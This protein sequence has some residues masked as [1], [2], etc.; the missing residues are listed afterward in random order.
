MLATADLAFMRG[1]QADALPDTCAISRKTLAS[2][3]AGGY[4]E[5]WAT[6]GSGVACRLAVART[7]ERVMA[8]HIVHEGGFVVTLPYG[9]AVTPKDR[10]LVGSR[11]FE[12]TGLASGSWETA[13]RASCSE[14]T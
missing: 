6:V 7:G 10:I 14:V 4:T 5:T 2:D 12:V 8:D 1:Q 9:T 11:T 13:V 3:G